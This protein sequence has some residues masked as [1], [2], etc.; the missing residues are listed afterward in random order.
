MTRLMM[1][2][3][4]WL[5]FNLPVIYFI[6][7][8][9]T[10][11]SLDELYHMIYAILLLLPFVFFPATIALYAVVRQWVIGNK[12]KLDLSV[13]WK[14]YKENY[15]RSLLIGLIVTGFFIV[16]IVNYQLAQ[17]EWKSGL[18]YIYL[19][20]T[21]SLLAI[22]NAFLADTVH[23]KLKFTSSIKKSIM[24]GLFFPHYS[25]SIIG[26]SVVTLYLLYQLHPFIFLLFSGVIPAVF[27]FYGYY[28]LYKR[29][30]K[31]ENAPVK[32][33]QK[34]AVSSF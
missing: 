31:L 5:G 30:Q 14:A 27:G 8:S 22:I 15:F 29:A 4:I 25:I 2:N 21:V 17:I 19:V 7:L 34:E 20:L 3:G 11:R 24:I 13:F 33:K 28:H 6:L 12:D 1:V 10:V 32:E 18:F 23:L 16:W 9:M 26:M